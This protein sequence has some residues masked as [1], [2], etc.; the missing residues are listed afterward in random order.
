MHKVEELSVQSIGYSLEFPPLA[1]LDEGSAASGAI[2]GQR[3]AERALEMGFEMEA[4]GYNI[5]VSGPS[6]TG[7]RTAVK[8]I[9]EQYKQKKEPLKDVAFVCNYK[10]QERPKALLFNEGGAVKFKERMKALVEELKA[11]VKRQMQSDA[12]K[13]ERDKLLQSMEELERQKLNDFEKRAEAASFTV[14]HNKAGS[15]GDEA[16]DL[17]PLYQGKQT[18]FDQLQALL[19]KGQLSEEEW[20]NWRERYYSC[21]DDM[22]Q[23]FSRLR[24]E[25]RKLDEALLELGRKSV[26]P[27]L[28]LLIETMIHD[29]P[30]DGI[31]AYLQET[32]ADML[33]LL[34]LFEESDEEDEEEESDAQAYLSR[35]NVNVILDNSDAAE[36]PI[37]FENNPSWTNLFGV[38]DGKAE[39]ADFMSIKAGSLIQASGGFLIMRLEDLLQEEDVWLHLK[40]ALQTEEAVIQPPPSPLALPVA[41]KPDAVKINAKVILVGGESLYDLLYLQDKDFQKLFKV[42]AEFDDSVEKNA[43]TALEY[44][45]F[46]RNIVQSEKLLPIDQSGI[47]AVLRYSVR[48][49]EDKKRFSARLS[50]IADTVR[51]SGYWAAKMG[52]EIICK[53]AVARALEMRAYFS[54]LP[55]E[56]IL[57]EIKEQTLILS[58]QGWAIGKINALVV[59]DRGFYSFGC[60]TLI[61]AQASSGKDGLINIEREAGLSGEI[62]D[63]GAFILEAFL[64]SRFSRETPLSLTMSLSFEQSYD[65]VEGD[66]AALAE[67]AALISAIAQAP[68]NQEIAVTGSINQFGEV[69]PVGGVSDKVEGFFNVCKMLGLTGAQGVII[70][71]RNIDNLFINEEISLAIENGKFHIWPVSII[72]EALEVLTGQELGLP[73]KRGAYPKKSLF[74][75]LEEQLKIMSS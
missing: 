31:A 3:R 32:K 74:G 8:R 20:K 53:A 58:V 62:H 44:A 70:P 12:Y 22:K 71:Q 54:N 38:I 24:A 63:K 57:R 29:F 69:Q 45:G 68:I 1:A 33:A 30:E 6:G 4:K 47:E 72:E 51:E 13:R 11:V 39:E 15:E 50:M 23:V 28:A 59:I 65:G 7:K 10:R 73:D 5:F 25:A 48:L 34:P 75:Q 26:E 27:D 67:T 55:Q 41:L 36:R 17:A 56:Q 42:V 18:D 43:Q 37:V 61:T 14:V 46:T 9:A 19:D 49:S 16:T 35:Y 40:R 60:P 64:R 66:S 21:M 2:V 52:N